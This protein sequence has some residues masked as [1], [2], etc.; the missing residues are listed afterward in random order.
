VNPSV[1]NRIVDLFLPLGEM[2][3]ICTLI[4]SRIKYKIKK[5]GETHCGAENFAEYQDEN[6]SSKQ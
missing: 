5:N 2:R 4:L 3:S 1:A 6:Q